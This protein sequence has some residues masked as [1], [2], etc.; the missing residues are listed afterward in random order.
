MVKFLILLILIIFNASKADDFENYLSYREGLSEYTGD[1]KCATKYETQL[2]ILLNSSSSYTNSKINKIQLAEPDRTDSLVTQHFILHWNESGSHSVP[3]VDISSNG[4]PD[5]IDSAATI[6]EHVWDVEINQMNYTPPPQQNGLP[7]STYHV[8]FTDMS[9]YGV[10]YGSGIDIPSLPG[11]NWTSYLELENDYQESFF[12]SQ[13]LDGLK[14]TAA[15][16]FHH[17]I[18]FGYN[19]RQEDFFFYEMTSTWIED[20]LYTEINDYFNYL[21]TLFNSVG[22]R[23]F[24]DYS[25]YA[26]GNCLYV[27]MI[28]N[29]FGEGIVK[30]IWDQIKSN[31]VI[32]AIST[33]LSKPAYNTSW[34]NLLAEYG[35]WLY[36]TGNRA[37]PNIYFP[38]GEYYPQITDY[39]YDI[40]DF[41]LNLDINSN[42]LANSFKYVK[43]KNIEDNFLLNLRVN[44]N[45]SYGGFNLLTSEE[46]SGFFYVGEIF[47]NVQLNEDSMIVLL[48]N[49]EN[50]GDSFNILNLIPDEFKIFPNFPNPFNNKTSILVELKDNVRFSLSIYNSLGEKINVLQK[51]ESK[52]GGY[53]LYN[54]YGK[55][56]K[57]KK[58]ASGFYIVAFESE[59]KSEHFKILYL[60]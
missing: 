58:V 15:H 19:V 20:Y 49:A 33:I 27:H 26:Y 54:W 56:T 13:G 39:A 50:N 23:S 10:T 31:T 36:Y 8:Y 60:K 44:S 14:V 12:Y 46:V 24:D 52:P 55:N 53:Y 7:V 6:L 18:Q 40:V 17:A 11:T 2:R 48:T 4:I 42:V 5:Y 22:N 9:Y 59:Q 43:I 41:N 1:L 37:N 45:I 38:E 51:K 34:I 35:V 28:V 21:P 3:L 16:E 30:Q 29:Q 57:G 32:P 25:L 47:N